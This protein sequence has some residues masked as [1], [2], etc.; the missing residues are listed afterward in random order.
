MSGSQSERQY[1]LFVECRGHP[2]K[3]QRNGWHFIAQSGLGKFLEN[4]IS[5]MRGAIGV[6]LKGQVKGWGQVG[7]CLLTRILV[8]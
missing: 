4:G 3:P 1:P 8:V 7:V 2:S 5:L 6:R